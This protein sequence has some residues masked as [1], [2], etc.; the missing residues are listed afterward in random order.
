MFIKI[1]L[2]A[3]IVLVLSACGAALQSDLEK[4][5]PKTE[6]F[7]KPDQTLSSSR[8][9]TGMLTNEGVMCQA[10]RGED[11]ILY[12][13]ENLPEGLENGDVLRVERD[14][15][16]NLMP[17]HCDQGQV[18]FWTAITK[19]ENGKPGQIWRKGN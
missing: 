12:V 19:L 14:S 8:V 9:I 7:Q 3:F 10:M 18:V 5:A 13:F 16:T 11:D 17:S 6:P 2:S 15:P 1:C 4:T